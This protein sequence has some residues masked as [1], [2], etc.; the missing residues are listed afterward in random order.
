MSFNNEFCVSG[1]VL[2]VNCQSGYYEMFIYDEKTSIENA[3]LSTFLMKATSQ[4]HYDFLWKE[5]CNESKWNKP[6]HWE[7][8]I[9]LMKRHGIRSTPIGLLV[10]SN[11]LNRDEDVKRLIYYEVTIDFIFIRGKYRQNKAYREIFMKMI[12]DM[13]YK[14]MEEI[15][16][17]AIK[18][19]NL[20]KWLNASCCSDGGRYFIESILSNY[21]VVW[22]MMS[23]KNHSKAFIDLT[24]EG[25]VSDG[26][27]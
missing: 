7:D 23:I 9:F 27:E 26:I 16:H 22:E 4:N 20:I 3:C 18:P 11:D 8:A 12:I 15:E 10:M 21:S 13:I 17:Y 14:N 6:R 5:L 1:P 24:E 25:F 2:D 19:K